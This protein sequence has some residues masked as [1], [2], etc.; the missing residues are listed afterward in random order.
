MTVTFDSDKNI[1]ANFELIPPA[2][3]YSINL[4]DAR[5]GVTVAPAGPYNDGDSVT[6]T[7]ASIAGYNF[8]G[9]S[10][11][12]DSASNPLTLTVSGDL[13]ITANYEAVAPPPAPGEKYT[14]TIYEFNSTITNSNPKA[15]YDAGEE[16]TLTAVP[17]TGYYFVNWCG[18]ILSTD[19]PITF[20]MDSD[21]VMMATIRE[22]EAPGPDPDPDPVAQYDLNITATNGTVNLN[23]NGPYDAGTTVQLTAVPDTGYKFVGW[24]GDVSGSITTIA[25]NMDSDKNVTATF[26]EDVAPV[27]YALNVTSNNG[28]V[29]LSQDGPYAPN[30][31]VTLT[32]TAA[33]GY[34]F[35]SWS[36]DVSGVT[37]PLT[38]N[39]NSDKNITANF[40]ADVVP[41]PDPEPVVGNLILNGE[42]DNNLTG[43]TGQYQAGGVGTFNLATSGEL[44]GDNYGIMNISNAGG[45]E[46]QVE[47]FHL[48]SM[49]AGKTYE[50]SFEANSTVTRNVNVSFQQ[51][52]GG[53]LKDWQT[54]VSVGTTPASYGPFIVTA[55][56][57]D[58]QTRLNFQMG[59]TGAGQFWL[60]NVVV[61]EVVAYS[62][63]TIAQNGAITLDPEQDL[64]TPGTVVT[65]TAEP[66]LDY[67]FSGWGGDADGTNASV[68]ITMDSDKSV[69]A[70]FDIDTNAPV[71]S[72]DGGPYN[73]EKDDTASNTVTITSNVD[74]TVTTSA[75]WIKVSA[76]SG[77]NDGSFDITVDPND[78]GFRAGTV[79]I[80]GGGRSDIVSVS[81]RGESG[82]DFEVVN[83]QSPLGTN[84]SSIV[85][86]PV[87][88]VFQNVAKNGFAWVDMGEGNYFQAQRNRPLSNTTNGYLN[89]GATGKMAILWQ[90]KL[91]IKGKWILTFDGDADIEL[92]ADSGFSVPF[93][94]L[95]KITDNRYEL[96]IGSG[97]NNNGWF[98]TMKL[99]RNSATNP[100][101]NL[102]F[103]EERFEGNLETFYPEFLENWK[104]F[105]NFPLH[106]L[107]GN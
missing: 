107:D 33:D 82:G 15:E 81:Q 78:G 58:P 13:D 77:S 56:S 21:I 92:F 11:D 43:W 66:A 39:M 16:V 83:Q 27:T 71:V 45:A 7:A 37:N 36:G 61:R 75:P 73:Y 101:R 38:I 91:D 42:F 35:T 94:N 41:D 44:S 8:T 103:Y 104:M 105:K 87:E 48:F 67:V 68:Q 57:T 1:T 65:L 30:T 64:Y 54:N 49:E 24:S 10:G 102:K 88:W 55:G 26:E 34:S 84:F 28:T 63:T 29:A 76:A 72:A 93:Q 70:T 51:N 31:S 85:P 62:L 14:L 100:M 23:A 96:N 20:T 53:Y 5:S 60:D 19:N 95:V 106:G 4:T 52:G 22:G 17:N 18:D 12:I 86:F 32:A 46:W 6:L 89:G 59:A 69:I 25:I 99:T 90:T 79:T 80:S 47:L 2:V 50:V 9:W 97:D 98:V 3:T 40:T 74:W